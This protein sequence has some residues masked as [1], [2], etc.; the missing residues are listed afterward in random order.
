MESLMEFLPI[1]L[2]SLTIVLVI[3][4]IILG[5]KLIYTID[6]ANAI[7]ED[8]EQKSR[9]LNGFFNVIDSV[10]DTL[11]VLSDTVVSSV[12]SII[13]KLIPKKRKKERNEDE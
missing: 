3:V 11:S 10:T 4:F 12:T 6:K 2:Y 8:V 13:G 5:V 1:M 9:S 7:L